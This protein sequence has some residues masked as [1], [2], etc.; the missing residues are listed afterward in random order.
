[1]LRIS[2]I[3]LGNLGTFGRL[4]EENYDSAE[5]QVAFD[6]TLQAFPLRPENIE[7]FVW[8][9]KQEMETALA[10]EFQHI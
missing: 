1:M 6:L 2:K 7:G 9:A 3:K 8:N 4:N 10:K 5:M